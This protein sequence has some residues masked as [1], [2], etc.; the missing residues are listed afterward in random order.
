MAVSHQEEDHPSVAEQIEEVEHREEEGVVS[1]RE[2]GELERRDKYES[3]T[4]ARTEQVTTGEARRMV[5]GVAICSAMGCRMT[6]CMYNIRDFTSYR[7]AIANLCARNWHVLHLGFGRF[8]QSR[9]DKLGLASESHSFHKSH[10][11]YRSSHLHPLKP[12]CCFHSIHRK[13]SSSP[14]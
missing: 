12:S 11:Q 5:A 3:I 4:R 2:G 1:L 6:C 10:V 14:P 8:E 7:K 9:L 13:Y